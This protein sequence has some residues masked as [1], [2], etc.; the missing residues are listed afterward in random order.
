MPCRAVASFEVARALGAPLDAFLVR[1]LGVPG[2]EELALG[3]I[4]SGAVRV[5]NA[6]VVRAL[7]I[8][9]DTIEAVTTR[10]EEEL[11]RRERAYRDDRPPPEIADQTVILVDDG[12]ATGATMRAAVA[13]RG[14]GSVRRSRRSTRS[15]AW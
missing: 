3:A 13:G 1:K 12:V 7:D 11:A 9:P 2:R 5:L 4:A 10:E 15:C 8:A 14:A 6:E